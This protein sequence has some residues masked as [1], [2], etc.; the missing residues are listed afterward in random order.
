MHFHLGFKHKQLRRERVA[1]GEPNTSLEVSKNSS[2]IKALDNITFVAGIAGP[3]TVLP[4][5]WQIF[6][7]HQA[8]GVSATSW[9]LMFIVTFPWIFYGIAHKDKAIIISFILWEVVNL[10]VVVGAVL[11][12]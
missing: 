10:I 11:Y 5:I 2:Y 4:Q 8:A 9:T 12:G 7:T 1:R 3:F 6:T